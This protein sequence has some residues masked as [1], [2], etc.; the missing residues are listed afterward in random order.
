METNLKQPSQE[1]IN[2]AFIDIVKASKLL[3]FELNYEWLKTQENVILH[4][5]IPS[6]KLLELAEDIEN[7]GECKKEDKCN[8]TL[9]TKKQELVINKDTGATYFVEEF[10]ALSPVRLTVDQLEEVY[11]KIQEMIEQAINN[12]NK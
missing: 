1:S 5:D 8:C 4:L 7:F 12:R 11:N 6:D 2:K 10:K 3:D 9:P